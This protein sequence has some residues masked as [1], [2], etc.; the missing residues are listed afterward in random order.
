MMYARTQIAVTI[1][2]QVPQP[3]TV[4]VLR[5]IDFSEKIWKNNAR[6]VTKEYNIPTII[7]SAEIHQYRR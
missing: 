5:W 2:T 7:C 1:P 6:E 4:C 3:F